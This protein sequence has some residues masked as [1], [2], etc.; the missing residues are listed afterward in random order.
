[1]SD[2]LVVHL[3]EGT[4]ELTVSTMAQLLA[5]EVRRRD[6]VVDGL[7]RR[8][9]GLRTE[10]EAHYHP[11]LHGAARTT[12]PAACGALR[13]CE[14]RRAAG[15]ALTPPCVGHTYLYHGDRAQLRIGD[16][17]LVA[18]N[19]RYAYFERCEDNAGTRMDL[20]RQV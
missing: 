9:R 13:D 3:R 10:L 1:M 17:C 12:E 16:G 20:L 4:D 14:A 8:V 6:G 7:E 18:R 11:G 5:P 15:C 2:G 19:G